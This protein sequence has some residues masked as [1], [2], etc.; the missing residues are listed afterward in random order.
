MLVEKL[1]RGRTNCILVDGNDID[2][3]VLQSITSDD[4]TDTACK[5]VRNTFFRYPR[6]SLPN[7]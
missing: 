1:V 5:Y 2:L 3:L 6:S 4:T 7:L